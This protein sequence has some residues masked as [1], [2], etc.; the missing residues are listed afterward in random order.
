MWT[1]LPPFPSRKN[2]SATNSPEASFFPELYVI[3]ALDVVRLAEHRVM[4]TLD[5]VQSVAPAS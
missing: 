1:F 2:S 5:L 3:R 4:P